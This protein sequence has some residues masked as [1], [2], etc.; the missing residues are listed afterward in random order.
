MLYTDNTTG[1]VPQQGVRPSHPKPPVLDPPAGS[2]GFTVTP[3]TNLKDGQV[4]IMSFHGL[5]P[6]RGA[7]HHHVLGETQNLTQGTNQCRIGTNVVINDHGRAT[8]HF[9]VH[10]FFPLASVSGAPELDCATYPERCVIAVGLSGTSGKP[11]TDGAFEP[12]TFTPSPSTQPVN[13]RQISV[14][15]PAPFTNGEVVMISGTGF[16]PNTSV[17]VGECPNDADCELS[18]VNTDSSGG[19][20]VPVTVQEFYSWGVEQRDCTQPNTCFFTAY[21]AGPP[22][23]AATAIPL[24]SPAPSG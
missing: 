12:V 16:A 15:P 23:G 14:S 20:S 9:A 2:G 22:Y 8:V 24:S 1:N 7:H 4:V 18:I 13:P 19:F 6:L 11:L 3:H 17:K 5:Q 10:R 21:D